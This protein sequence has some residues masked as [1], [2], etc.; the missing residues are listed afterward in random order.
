MLS[1]NWEVLRA[2]RA[3][4][5]GCVSLRYD[6]AMYQAPGLTRK[7]VEEI[8]VAMSWEGQHQ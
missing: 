5:R 6:L 8:L 3:E 1:Y 2:S 7:P 4:M